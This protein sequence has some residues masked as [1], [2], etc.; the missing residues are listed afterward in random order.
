MHDIVYIMHKLSVHSIES[1]SSHDASID[2][3][4]RD[5]KR[6]YIYS[7]VTEHARHGTPPLQVSIVQY[8][9]SSYGLVQPSI[10]Q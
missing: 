1:S 6:A 3:G 4:E 5:W 8:S 2:N 9:T 7:D 10:Q